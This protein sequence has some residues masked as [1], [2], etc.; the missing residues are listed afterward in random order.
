MDQVNTFSDTVYGT[1]R[2]WVMKDCP[3]TPALR[4][5]SIWGG[6]DKSEGYAESYEMDPKLVP[7][8]EQLGYTRFVFNPE[9]LKE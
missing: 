7:A 9:Q 8:L 2:L 3:F 5:L 6:P 1:V 4:K